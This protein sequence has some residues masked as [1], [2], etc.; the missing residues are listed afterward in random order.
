MNYYVSI[1]TDFTP[2][3]S[4]KFDSMEA[5]LEDVRLSFSCGFMST[6]DENFMGSKESS[7]CVLVTGP[8]TIF[9]VVSEERARALQPEAQRRMAHLSQGL[10]APELMRDPTK[11]YSIVLQ[12]GM[13]P[14]E[15]NLDFVSEEVAQAA[16]ADF[17][18]QLSTDFHGVPVFEHF[19]AEDDYVAI[20]PPPGLVMM[21]LSQ[22]GVRLRQRAITEQIMRAKQTQ[23]I[24]G[25]T[26]FNS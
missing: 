1:Y 13:R 18:H 25:P 6:V 23:M 26:I 15:P 4:Y 22:E 17:K 10:I 16:L 14:Y 8:G 21:L 11:G 2:H 12:F 5:A 24:K 19:Y 7:E 9:R 3:P 20:L